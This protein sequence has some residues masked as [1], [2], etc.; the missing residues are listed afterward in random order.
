MAETPLYSSAKEMAALT[1][2]DEVEREG[3][4]LELHECS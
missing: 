1:R 4:A 2:A 3:G